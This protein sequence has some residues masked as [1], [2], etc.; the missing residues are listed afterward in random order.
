MRSKPLL[1][2][3]IIISGM[4]ACTSSDRR[5]NITGDIGGLPVQTV[6]LEQLSAND[7][8]TIIDSQ[9]SKEDGH[10]ELSGVSP[11]PGL[12]RLH[13]QPNKYILLS[14]DKG[15][16]KVAADWNA[17]ENYSVMGSP[18][19]AHLKSF[20]V[21]IRE[22]L[23]DFN[24][25]SIVLYTLK[26]KGNDSVLDAA[27]K[28]FQD[29]KVQFTQYVEHYADT[30]PY[31]PNCVFA[32]RILNPV[33][34]SN[35][36]AAF[37]QGLGRKF[38]GTKMTKEFTEYYTKALAKIQQ[39]AHS[40]ASM[41]TGAEAPELTL[42]APD[43]KM[44]ALSSLR[45]K[46]VLLDFWAS[47]CGPCRAENPNVVAAYERYKDKNFTVYGVSLDNKKEAWEKAIKDDGLTWTHVSDLKGWSSSAAV[48]Y[49]IQSIPS[50]ILIDPQG[51]IVARNL[52]GEELEAALEAVLKSPEPAASPAP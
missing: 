10:F 1:L 26:A 21:G 20:V 52:R 50:N 48:M 27:K 31:E 4:A 29:M 51:K 5:F 37:V 11:E 22:H 45:G 30:T 12:Y 14:V 46:Y 3:L 41:E 8:I 40:N 33:T 38:P 15:N 23:R 13:F 42:P 43:G 35:Y 34:E 25:M 36:L 39:P 18:Q 2:V 6:I 9:R 47:W 19:S 44:I 49:S 28:D 32:A 16:I 7:I 24:T 17:L